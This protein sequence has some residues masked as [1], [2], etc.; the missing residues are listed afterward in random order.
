MRTI[1][2]P[3][4]KEEQELRKKSLT[5]FAHG[6]HVSS[7]DLL[8]RQRILRACPVK[9]IDDF[10]QTEIEAMTA[11]YKP[12]PPK[13]YGMDCILDTGPYEFCRV[14]DLVETRPEWLLWAIG[15]L[16]GFFVQDAVA[17]AARTKLEEQRGETQSYETES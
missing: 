11:M 10:D 4:N 2:A 1:K 7:L 16:R 9:T 12:K 14:G 17:G 15:N 5:V 8:S 6:G 3:K 13:I